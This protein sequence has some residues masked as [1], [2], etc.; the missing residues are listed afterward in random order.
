M[1]LTSSVVTRPWRIAATIASSFE[2]TPSFIRMFWMCVR[3]VFRLTP[4]SAAISSGAL[5][6]ASS[7]RI[8]SS[9]RVSRSN[10]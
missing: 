3:S 8:W 5:P 4:S 2:C 6:S 7:C 10:R 9:R 1:A